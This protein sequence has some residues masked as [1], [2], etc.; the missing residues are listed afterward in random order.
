MW[1]FGVL[2]GGLA[3]GAEPGGGGDSPEPE[4]VEV[5]ATS[6]RPRWMPQFRYPVESV[7]NPPEEVVCEVR[8][9]VD[10]Q[11]RT[12]RVEPVDCPRPF[13]EEVAEKG[14]EARFDPPIRDG[15]PV[16][17]AYNLTIRFRMRSGRAPGDPVGAG[18]LVWMGLTSPVLPLASETATAP[19]GLAFELGYR[20]PG[21][22]V[23][24]VRLGFD[25]WSPL[26]LEADDGS[27]ART[28]GHVFL[29]VDLFGSTQPDWAWT[30]GLLPSVG[31]GLGVTADRSPGVPVRRFHGV[32]NMGAE[33][34]FGKRLGDEDVLRLGVWGRADVV[35][36]AVRAD[37]IGPVHLGVSL[38]IGGAG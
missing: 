23:A 28:Q 26:T 21:R 36:E 34:W 24:G 10:A 30:L 29:G 25:R 17:S 7:P 15:E 32:M 8:F 37:R 22:G 1:L 13:W 18:E 38:G 35:P 16:A 2:L 31:A 33:L 4:R 11:G 19:F 5:D 6:V 20:G 14:H 9:V 27:L 12:E 3:W